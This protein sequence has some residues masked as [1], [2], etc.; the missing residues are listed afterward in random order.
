MAKLFTNT[1]VP[2]GFY[3]YDILFIFSLFVKGAAHI[4]I[5][6]K[7]AMPPCIGCPNTID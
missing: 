5:C 2:T 6:T 1:S 4:P 7:A 3:F